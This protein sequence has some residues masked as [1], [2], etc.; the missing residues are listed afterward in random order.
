MECFIVFSDEIGSRLDPN[1][2]HPTRK[3]IIKKLKTTSYQLLPLNDVVE[4]VR[5]LVI[6]NDSK[7]TYIGLENIESNTGIYIPSEEPKKSFGSAFKFSKGDILFPKL[8]PYLNKVHLALFDGICSTEF[9][10][11]KAKKCNNHYLFSFLNSNLILT[12]TSCLMTGNT[13]PRL[14]TEDIEK[15][16]IPIP[17]IE[18]QNRV[19]AIMQSAFEKKKQKEKEAAELL[20]AIDDYVLEE[21]GIKM[22][23]MKD[24]TCYLISSNEIE[25]RLDTYYHQPKFEEIHK[26]I[27]KGGYST[28]LLAKLTVLI[29]SGQRPKGGVRQI[30]EG[31]PSLGGEHILSNGIVATE[32][33][34]YIPIEFHSLHTDSKIEKKDVLLVKDGA[35]TGKTG[36]IPDD[37]P[38][39]EANINE[40]VFLIRCNK[41]LNP[42]YLLSFL[43]SQLGQLIIGREITGATIMGIIRDSIDNLMIPV[44]PISIQNNIAQEIK[45][46]MSKAETMKKEGIEAIELAKKEIEAIIL[47]QKK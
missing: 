36:I 2:Y 4:F 19:V 33:L 37:Y 9:H 6:T 22:P 5:D 15:L 47:E 20:G 17:P 24:M 12:Q 21:L 38:F 27:N 29:T 3:A 16:L 25:N 34:K 18:I 30:S 11:I 45:Q 31:I 26:A 8:R 41:R 10:V 28:E 1:P 44:P 40:H 42:Y 46:R 43:R 39:D 7:Q 32:D 14:Q 13:L 23:E 35:T